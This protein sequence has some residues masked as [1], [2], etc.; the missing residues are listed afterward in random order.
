MKGGDYA[1]VVATFLRQKNNGEALTIVGDGLQK[2]DFTYVSDV[3]EAN[4]LASSE[5]I[6]GGG[7]VANIGAGDSRSIM[8]L[9]ELIG[10]DIVHI[11]ERAGEIRNSFADIKKAKR[12][13]GWEPKVTLKE[14]IGKISFN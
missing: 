13:L 11:K 7:E 14:G 1:A 8:E 2:R 6:K 5:K 12:I 3:V 4:I 9:A 10:G